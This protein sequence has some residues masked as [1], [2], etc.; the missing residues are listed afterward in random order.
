MINVEVGVGEA[1]VTV[2]PPEPRGRYETI[3]D[4]PVAEV[5]V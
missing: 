5:K 1:A 4:V 2:G 3:Q